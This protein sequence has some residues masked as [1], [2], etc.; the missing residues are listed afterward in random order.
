[1]PLTQSQLSLWVGQRMHSE[2]PLH[3]VVYAFDIGGEIDVE[4][5]TKAFQL[6]LDTTDALRTVFFETN[7]TPSQR[8]RPNVV[9]ELETLDFTSVA[10]E[11]EIR[12]WLL[13]RAQYPLSIT[14]RTFDTVLLKISDTRYI[15]YLNIHH[16]VTDAVSFTIVYGR[17]NVLYQNILKGNSEGLEKTP[18]FQEYVLFEQRQG[19]DPENDTFRKYWE[20]KIADRPSIP[21]LYGNQNLINSTAAKRYSFR[22]DEN[23][24]AVFRK[25]LKQDGVW[26]L[27]ANLSG[28][29]IFATL[30]FIYL[31]RIS[32]QQKL[33]IGA[34]A[35]NRTN[36]VSRHTAGLF[37]E[38]LPLFAELQ[39]EDTFRT[40]LERV[41]EETLGFLRNVRPGMASAE[42]GKIFNAVLN[43][44]TVHFT[45]FNGFTTRTEWLHSGYMD[46]SHAM[47]LHINDFNN[48][49]SLDL[50]FDLNASIF[51]EII[52]KNVS[53]HFLNLFD[54]LL[55]DIDAPIGGP[56]LLSKKERQQ[57]MPE[58]RQALIDSTKNHSSYTSF[59]EGFEKQAARRPNAVAL[60]DGPEILTYGNLNKRANQLAHHL[61]NQGIDESG[62]VALHLYR[63][64]EYI[65][66]LLA[67]LKSGAAFIP[68]ASDQPVERVLYMYEN[69][70]SALL[71]TDAALKAKLDKESKVETIPT[72][73]LSEVSTE[74]SKENGSNLGIITPSESLA[75]ILYTSG[76][77][78][79][80]KGVM[81]P[82][83]ALSNYLDWAA[84]A[85]R[86][87]EKS[88][89][90][91]FTSIGF[92]LTLTAT[93]LPLLQGGRIIVYKEK[94]D[95]ADIALLQVI[96]DNAVN[97]IKLT[98]SH[99]QLLNGRNLKHS[100]IKTMIVGGEDLKMERAK[101]VSSAFSE[102]L[103]IYNEYGPTEA[104][105]GCIV[106]E[107]TRADDTGTSVSIGK[108]IDNIQ[109]FVLDRFKNL[110]PRGV[111]GE[112]YLSGTG[113]ADGYANNAEMTAAKFMGHPFKENAKMYRTGDLARINI[114]GNFEFL[115]RID[116]QIKLR[117]H[118]IEL[119]DIEANLAAHPDI[120]NCAVV[121]VENKERILESEVV[122]CISCGLPSNYPEIDFDEHGVCQLCTSFSK[123]EH[124]VERYFKNDAEL[125]NLLTSKRVENKEYDCISLLSGGKDS[126]YVLARLVDMGLKVLAFTLDNGY[127]SDQAKANVDRIVTRLGVDHI[128]GETPHMNEIFVDSLHR[129]HN[130]CNGCFKTIYTLSTQLALEKEIPFIVTG[131]SR[132]QFF[133]TRLTEELF[134]DDAMNTQKID[135]TILE[136][137]KLYHR[138]SDAVKK[139]LDV[140]AFDDDA[141]FEKIQFVDFY[142]Y[143][144]VSL[145][146]LLAYLKDKIG[147]VR[148]TDTGR[149]TNCLINQVGI[150][151][152]K[153][154]EGYSNYAFPY[155]W[156]VRLGHKT[157]EESL[158]EIN[159]RI[160]TTEVERIM[161]E[162]GYERSEMDELGGQ[163]LVAYFTGDHNI[164]AKSLRE[165]L[166]K[167][168]PHYMVPT[169]FR[170]LDEMPL[171]KNGKV[172]KL[173]LQQLNNA[174]LAMD[175]PYTAPRNEIELLL[176]GIWKE[177]LQLKKIGV[178]DEFIALGG[179]SL[180]AI[181]VTARINEEIE[182]DF[183]LNKVFE[184]S[185][186]AEYGRFIEQTLTELLENN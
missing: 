170:P 55:G 46:S 79:R 61:K 90:P 158:E 60:Q 173:S 81:I 154:E 161:A 149:S 78:G 18:A 122:N 102:D 111:P 51:P 155:S 21:K 148:P 24:T 1:M 110:V 47:R 147:W 125:V 32:G 152:H 72:L 151:V 127:I 131:L 92:D 80:P 168:L 68:I 128:Y 175:T 82:H 137:R 30:Y 101:Y 29:T 145:E 14:E 95:G 133:E 59:I 99:L 93:L 153:K 50:A 106:H 156:D 177:V 178:H 164:P 126:T 6:V 23:R 166:S 83:R 172:D 36:T 8:V 94:N 183:P 25:M 45:D 42:T 34:P 38:V 74:E 52:A 16:L 26:L 108:P 43:Y 97:T 105:V 88:V 162:I 17:M 76:S 143:S 107:Y 15:W 113:L 174:Q 121:L 139:L 132:G 69:S 134:W 84:K 13:K 67:V 64:A 138:E 141:V 10:E 19:K 167:R 56:S 119:S 70:R 159:E 117:G 160:D 5:F 37:L 96:E 98:P 136:A 180:A 150:Y 2:D 87:N 9:F 146:E 104:T 116:D 112:L 12:D 31:N 171:T 41:Q 179:H 120:E 75:Y 169:H 185:T 165:F 86:I 33:A 48:E 124:K 58:R 11:G 118:R 62:I 135:D 73:L 91:L 181:R 35:H 123:Y 66:G 20:E 89:F 182:V 22:L 184:L 186:I 54:A 100:F 163:K 129:H 63:S 49:G 142:R 3:N 44:I 103:K 85:Y 71:I 53:H 114:D 77:T 109:A 28:F 144:D 39:A 40:L 7:G 157:R 57:L 27:N 65:V 176:E 130:V 4:I 140:S 115:G